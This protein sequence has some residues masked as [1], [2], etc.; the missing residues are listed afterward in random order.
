MMVA[1]SVHC[2]T[3]SLQTGYSS[4]DS[5]VPSVEEVLIEFYDTILIGIELDVVE[6]CLTSVTGGC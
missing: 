1:V 3:E 4:V 5:A 2:S 6:L